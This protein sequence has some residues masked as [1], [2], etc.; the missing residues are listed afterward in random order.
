MRPNVTCFFDDRTNSATYVV[1]DPATSKAAVIDPVLDFDPIAG[2]TWT[3]S[4]DRVIVHVRDRGLEVEWLLETHV[5]ADH[6]SAARHLQSE[7][8]GTRA[9][10]AGIV[11]VQKTFG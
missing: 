9:I 2:R 5:H 1:S 6:L 3:E 8:G 7:I 10:G 4:A 11:A